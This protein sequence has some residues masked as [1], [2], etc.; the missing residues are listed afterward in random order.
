MAH[1]PGDVMIL[2]HENGRWVIYNAFARSALGVETPALEGIRAAEKMDLT[3][4]ERVYQDRFFSVWDIQRFFGDR[5]GLMEDPSR[6]IR[7]A[8]CWPEA[9]SIAISELVKRLKQH[10][11]LVDDLQSYRARFAPKNSVLDKKHFGN[12]HQQLGQE[13]ML[14]RRQDPAKWWVSQKFAPDMLSIKEG[15][16]RAIQQYFLE[17]YFPARL[18]PGNTVLDVGC[19]TGFYSNMMARTGAQVL[20]IDPNE[21]YIEVASRCAET[22]ARFSAMPIGQKGAMDSIASDSMD[23]VFMSDALLFY[24]VPV[25]PGFEADI[26][27]LLAEIHRVL[28]PTGRFI[29]LEPHSVFYQIPWLGEETAPI[30]INTEYLTKSFGIT[31]SL[32]QLVQAYARAGFN[33]SWMEELTPDP[34]SAKDHPR[35]YSFAQQ[36]PQ[37]HLFELA[38]KKDQ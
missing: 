15:P 12:L 38:P 4:L 30:A 37:W 6:F 9:E 2:P 32:G 5:E 27:I 31:P 11:L 25:G 17:K 29:S 18:A 20:G 3:E 36:F 34:D 21:E 22:G 19:G 26:S 14:N 28:K 16:Y 7:D 33:V 10:H 1:V 35:A 13:L 24:F 23:F 8:G